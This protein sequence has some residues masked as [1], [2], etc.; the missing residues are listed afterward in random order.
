[1][2][3]TIEDKKEFIIKYFNS[4]IYADWL[5]YLKTKELIKESQRI[6]LNH[7]DAMAFEKYIT[8]GSIE[9]SEEILFINL[10]YKI[11]KDY[12]NR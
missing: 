11:V 6:F 3:M 4:F 5:N 1:M 7:L 10:I 8:F 12:D 9:T 2:N